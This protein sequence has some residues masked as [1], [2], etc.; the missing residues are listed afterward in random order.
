MTGLLGFPPALQLDGWLDD[1]V[2]DDVSADLLSALRESLSNAA[3]HAGASKVDVQVHA[4]AE[5]TLTVRDNGSGIEKAA[6]RRSGLSNLEQRA[7]K[8]GG[9]LRIEPVPGGGTVLEWRVPL[10]ELPGT[11][12]S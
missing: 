9:S 7:T 10:A 4:G 5:L 8:L 6:G 1:D 11:T 3:R 12:A 2:P